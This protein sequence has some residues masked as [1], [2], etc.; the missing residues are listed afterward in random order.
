MMSTLERLCYD[1]DSQLRDLESRLSQYEQ[2]GEAFVLNLEAD[3]H[4]VNAKITTTLT[5]LDNLVDKEPFSRRQTSKLR[6]DQI[7][8]DFQH[9]KAALRTLQA[10]RAQRVSEENQRKELLATDFSALS[11]RGQTAINI[12]DSE[13]RH[14]SSMRNVN[15]SV[16]RMRWFLSRLLRWGKF[17]RLILLSLPRLID[18]LVDCLK[19]R[20]IDWK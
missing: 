8:Y 4:E 6:V 14:H 10:R 7:R 1:T 17:M 19:D 13:L 2:V 20:S 18:W 9:L 16:V 5:K 11:N 12:Q 15:R 3:I